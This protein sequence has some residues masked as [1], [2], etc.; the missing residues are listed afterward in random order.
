MATRIKHKRSSVA[1]KQPIVSQLES[2]ELAINTADGKV[3]LLRD[4][5]TVQDITKRIFENNSE[6]VVN[7]PGDSVGAITVTV[8]GVDKILVTP[9]GISL[10]DDTTVEDAGYITFKELTA[11]GNDGIGIKAPNTLDAG[12]NLTLPSSIGVKV[13]CLN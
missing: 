4:D 7:D 5:N 13:T 12:Y 6:I 2:G 3:F 10:Q 8:D 1:G 11:S 9:S